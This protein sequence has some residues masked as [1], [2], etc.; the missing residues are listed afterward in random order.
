MSRFLMSSRSVVLTGATSGIGAVLCQ[1]LLAAGH[2]VTVVARRASTLPPQTGLRTLDCDLSDPGAVQQ[3]VDEIAMQPGVDLLINNAAVQY[4]QALIDPALDVDRLQQEIAVN[5]LAP[6]IL[7]HG[8]AP[9]MMATGRPGLIVNVNS[10]L[11]I[12]PKAR[13]ALYCAAKAG[14][15][16]LSQS[17]A[18]QLEGSSIRVVDAYLPLVDTPMTEGRGNGKLTAQ[19]AGDAILTGI[20]R[21]QRRIWIGK[22][23]VL[24]W[25]SR[26]APGVARMA[27]RGPS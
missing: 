8:L 23:A 20:D 22:A 27:L 11:A 1:R 14:L 5:L 7:I 13:T 15:H 16:S 2:Q 17:L 10:G 3:A 25:L 12:Y 26:L 24:P 18:Y 21:R 9:A 6:A 19:Q 4:D